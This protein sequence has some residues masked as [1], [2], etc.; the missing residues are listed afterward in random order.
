MASKQ[1]NIDELKCE[2]LCY[3]QHYFGSSSNKG[4][5][6]TISGFFTLEEVLAAKEL[7]FSVYDDIVNL[8][9]GE[10]DGIKKHRFS[11]R[12]LG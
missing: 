10:L 3:I 12:K 11:F 8:N 7:L 4:L 5:I 2:L 9:D 6:V 1:V